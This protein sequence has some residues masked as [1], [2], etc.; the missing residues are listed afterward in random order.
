MCLYILKRCKIS[1][2]RSIGFRSEEIYTFFSISLLLELLFEII[3]SGEVAAKII[4]TLRWSRKCNT[5]KLWFRAIVR[6]YGVDPWIRNSQLTKRDDQPLL[7]H[8][9]WSSETRNQTFSVEW[10]EGMFHK[11]L[12]LTRAWWI[13]TQL[14]KKSWGRNDSASYPVSSWQRHATQWVENLE[15]GSGIGKRILKTILRFTS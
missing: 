3:W 10:L 1:T 9:H 14:S 6:E 8:G 13:Y 2:D 4:T 15:F 11:L 5:H 12:N 7:L